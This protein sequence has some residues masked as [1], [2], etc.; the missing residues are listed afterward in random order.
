[1]KRLKIY[2]GACLGSVLFTLSSCEPEMEFTNPSA[3]SE[4]NYYNTKEHLTY[5]VNG[6]Y[7]MLQRAG[8]WARWM[9]FMLNARS[10]E[11]AFTS[12][13]AAGEPETAR[14][15]QYTVNAD[16]GS[17]STT[18]QDM[19]TL[20]YAANLALEKLA[21]NQDG[22]FDLNNTED[23]NLYD[24]LRG[25]A[26]F[27]RGLSRFYL[28]YFFGDQI[29]DRDY[30]TTGGADYSLPPAESGQIYQRMVKDFQD[31]SELLTAW[32][33]EGTNDEGRA[34]KGSA[35]AFLAKCYMGRPILDG[36]AK[37]GDADWTSAK[38]VLEQIINSGAYG[39]MDNYR[40]NATEDNENNKESMFEVQFCQSTETQGFNPAAPGDLNSWVVTG[41]N[42]IRELE[43]SAPN[44][45]ECGRWWNGMPSLAL[46]N[47]FERDS[48]GKI[49]DPRAYLG[50][51]IPDG[52]KFLGKSGKWLPYEE[53]F[54]GGTF[55]AWRGK[56]F[57]C[58]KYSLDKVRSVEQSGINDRLIRY[59]DILLMYAECCLETGDE[60]TAKNY[61]QLVRNR[62][63]NNTVALNTT[64]ADAGMSYL[65]GGKL[66][67]VDE[68]IAN[69][70][71]VGRV[72]G[73]NGSVI[74]EGMEI[75]TVRRALKHEYSVELYWE[76]WR[77]FNLM[78]WYNNPNDPDR[79]RMLDNLI[80]KN[81]AQVEQTSLTGTATF[82][83]ER[84]LYLPIPSTE[85]T[86]NPNM[87]GNAAN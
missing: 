55:D 35:L 78:R 42:T 54:S 40:D 6:A 36:T 57:G 20:Q 50:M 38:A 51:Y 45:T 2:I 13:A 46:Y 1:M 21:A 63:N 26:I 67:T 17:L 70:P 77:F 4:L 12:G 30:V 44:S 84:N 83:Y 9:P 27:L 74:C 56:W 85:L 48:E 5:A 33:Y 71:V 52:C 53:L 31:A 18:F 68:L 3:D 87:H 23:K 34:T 60:A 81:A 16:L 72:V 58:R 76:G 41:Q 24:R 86:T 75:N 64:E 47:E 59:A 25:E 65:E 80:N 32:N 73:N 15:S 8:G 62:A 22:A 29:P 82:N 11:Y 66:P 49:I 28:V 69:H 79:E 7:N 19:Y 39:L 14:L 43:L 37:A 10:D 61:I